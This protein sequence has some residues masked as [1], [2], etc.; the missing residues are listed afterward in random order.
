MKS[1]STTNIFQSFN[2]DAV[3]EIGTVTDQK[4]NGY[5]HLADLCRA[6]KVSL[7]DALHGI[8][9][10]NLTTFTVKDGKGHGQ[11]M[12]FVNEKG[13]YWVFYLS[14]DKDAIYFQDWL[15]KVFL[16]PL[17]EQQRIAAGRGKN[18]QVIA[19][20]DGELLALHYLITAENVRKSGHFKIAKDVPYM[21]MAHLRGWWY[22]T[23]DD[24][25]FMLQFDCKSEFYGK[26][27]L[28]MNVYLTK[29]EDGDTDSCDMHVS[30]LDLDADNSELTYA[31]TSMPSDVLSKSSILSFIMKDLFSYR[32]VM[33]PVNVDLV[34][35]L[36]S[37]ISFKRS[38]RI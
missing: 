10:E 23:N 25:V 33:K 24:F 22:N 38:R 19:K 35:I 1:T 17:H 8:P 7:K 37:T 32:E 21:A 13:M 27:N 28:R 5:F 29:K 18:D 11:P 3:G 2:N 9:K 12:L 6:L 16:N 34:A 36:N 14:D 15:D 4:Y 26:E 31:N 30:L 20:R